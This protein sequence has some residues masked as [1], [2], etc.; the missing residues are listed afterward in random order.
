MAALTVPMRSPRGA[1]ARRLHR[2]RRKTMP[3]SV[4]QNPPSARRRSPPGA[5]WL[6]AVFRLSLRDMARQDPDT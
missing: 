4:P 2:S 3:L 1:Y 6:R 5:A